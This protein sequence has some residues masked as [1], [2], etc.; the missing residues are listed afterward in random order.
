MYV[1]L[2]EFVVLAAIPGQEVK[3]NKKAWELSVYLSEVS[4]NTF[5]EINSHPRKTDYILRCIYGKHE[6]LYDILLH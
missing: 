6:R 2:H 3:T 1:I 5:A 4:P